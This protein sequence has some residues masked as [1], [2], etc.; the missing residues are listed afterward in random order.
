MGQSSGSQT[1]T[2]SS[3]SSP[4]APTQPLLKDIVGSLGGVNTSLTP[5]QNNAISQ[6]QANSQIM[7]NF[8]PSVAGTVSNLLGNIPNLNNDMTA[9]LKNFQGTMA[10]F[11][12]PQYLNPSSN[13]QEKNLIDTITQ[14]VSNQIGGNF[15]AAGR[16]F[17]PDMAQAEARGLSQGLAAPLFNQYNQNVATQ[18]GAAQNLF[19]A[20]NLANN[21][22]LQNAGW[23][24]GNASNIPQLTNMA[25]LQSLAASNLGFNLPLTQ[26][27]AVENM[28]LPIAGL[29]GQTQSQGQGTSTYNPSLMSQ[30]QQGLMIGGMLG[31]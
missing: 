6:I 30:I 7:P 25:P 26:Q 10:P 16:A 27:G 24:I 11:T 29:G 20:A 1:Q 23:G 9:A 14:D 5:Q 13:P 28:V 31:I 17:S 2:Q 4:W 15:A 22:F 21:T 3:Q 12:N 18:T 8:G 19:N